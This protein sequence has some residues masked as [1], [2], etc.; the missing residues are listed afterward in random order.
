[1]SCRPRGATL[2]LPALLA[3][4]FAPA[5]RADAGFILQTAS[6][7]GHTYY[8][9]AENSAKQ[10]ITWANAETYAAS[11]GGHLATVNDA[12]ENAFLLSTFQESAIAAKASAHPNGGLLSM[13]IGYNDA[14]SEGNF[15]WSGGGGTGYT[16]WA[17][18]EPSGNQSDE[19][20]AAILVPPAFGLPGQWHDVVSDFRFNDVTYGLVEVPTTTSVPEPASA[21]LLTVGAAVLAGW[22]WRR[23]PTTAEPDAAPDRAGV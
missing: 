14:A 12:A 2:F 9:V 8:L 19:D 16:N 1:M 13:W 3:L 18:G 22:N 23:K 5:P 7:N 17:A 15:V 10:R 20:Y 4:G 6:Y 11:L 21:V